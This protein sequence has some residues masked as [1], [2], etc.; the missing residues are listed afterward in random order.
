MAAKAIARP[1]LPTS[2]GATSLDSLV[3]AR[4]ASGSVTRAELYRDIAAL[5]EPHLAV[6]DLKSLLDAALQGLEAE[7]HAVHEGRGRWRLGDS[8]ASAVTSLLGAAP[9]GVGDW[10]LVRNHRLV[11]AALGLGSLSAQRLKALGRPDG[12]RAAVLH[13]AYG[14]PLRTVTSPARLRNQL[15]VVALERA[16][17][18]TMKSGLGAGEGLSPKAGRLLAGQLSLRP[19]DFGTDSRLVGALAAECVGASRLDIEGLRLAILRRWVG[20]LL[21]KT[22]PEAS[23]NGPAPS[24][25]APDRPRPPSITAPAVPVPPAAAS[26]PDLPGFAAAVQ[27]AARTKSHGWPGNYKAYVSHVWQALTEKHPEW[28][29]TEV[30]F[31]GMLA[32]A[33]RTGHV[34]LVNADLKDRGNLAEVQRSAITYKNT[35]WHLVRVED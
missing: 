16:F 21:G 17:G 31:K 4:L 35:V 1:D 30:E 27:A 29:L 13:K 11:A 9:N 15:A 10:T 33:H 5:A 24:A 19:R 25:V 6:V 20:R 3:L 28:G 12:L 7:G 8:A 22:Q 32:E 18:N 26:R 34:R 23:S 2:N 14:L